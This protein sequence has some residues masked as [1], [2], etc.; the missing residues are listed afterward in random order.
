[1]LPAYIARF[2]ALVRQSWPVLLR[3]LCRQA[4][5]SKAEAQVCSCLLLSPLVSACPY[6]LSQRSQLVLQLLLSAGALTQLVV[7]GHRARL[8]HM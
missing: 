1:M 7:H 8:Q 5:M 4:P 6:L 3:A 2:A